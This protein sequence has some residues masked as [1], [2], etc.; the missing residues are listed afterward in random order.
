MRACRNTISVQAK[1][2]INEPV[3]TA[4]TAILNAIRANGGRADGN[5]RNL[6]IERRFQGGRSASP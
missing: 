4:T 2:R 5:N 3:Y 1:E 6:S